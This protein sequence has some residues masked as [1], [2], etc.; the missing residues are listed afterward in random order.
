MTVRENASAM[1]RALGCHKRAAFRLFVGHGF[2]VLVEGAG[3]PTRDSEEAAVR[4]GGVKSRS[5]KTR[6]EAFLESLP[7]HLPPSDSAVSS[8]R[9]W[10]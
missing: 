3:S 9:P 7:V 8:S 4:E 2:R 10:A 1:P 5:E 6:S